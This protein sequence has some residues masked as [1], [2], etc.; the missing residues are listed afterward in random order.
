[1]Q[2]IHKPAT[3]AMTALTLTLLAGT[4]QAACAVEGLAYRS[5]AGLP[6]DPTG[7]SLYLKDS[8]DAGF[9][10]FVRLRDGRFLDR[11]QGRDGQVRVLIRGDRSDCPTAGRLR[12]L[13]TA[14]GAP[15]ALASAG[16]LLTRD[17]RPSRPAPKPA[18]PESPSAPSGESAGE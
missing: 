12:D 14:V 16:W 17:S 11:I 9:A 3:A 5:L 4:A 6:D 7:P 13:G 2:T 15:Q 18:E 10:T 8:P 1:M